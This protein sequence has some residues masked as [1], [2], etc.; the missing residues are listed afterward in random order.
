MKV[1]FSGCSFTWGDELENREEQRFSRLVCNKLEA[2]ETN[3]SECGYSN[4]L[5]L[6]KFIEAAERSKPDLGIIQWSSISRFQVWIDGEWEQI[7][8]Q[9]NPRKGFH[10]GYMEWKVF[11]KYIY[12]DEM[13]VESYYK[14]VYL[15]EQYCKDKQIPLIMLNMG[16]TRPKNNNY[17]SPYKP[18]CKSKIEII[19]GGSNK[20]D[21]EWGLVQW[22][23]KKCWMERGHPSPEG[24]QIIADYL[25]QCFDNLPG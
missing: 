18:L 4:D 13:G 7:Q 11:Y 25:I 1:L 6:Q 12:S 19:T 22:D 15:A 20:R 14:N 24:H 17:I 8:V 16:K 23:D 21:G 9:R 2:E 5:I 10:N 3:V